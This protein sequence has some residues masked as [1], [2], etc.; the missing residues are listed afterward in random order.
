MQ[1]SGFAR[2]EPRVLS[3]Q[4]FNIMDVLDS[5]DWEAKD[6]THL[7]DPATAD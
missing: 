1:T 6:A 4:L 5:R 2:K 3:V 7:G